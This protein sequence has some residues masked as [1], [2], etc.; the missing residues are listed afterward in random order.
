MTLFSGLP[1]L[2]STP[3]NVPSIGEIVYLASYVFKVGVTAA[4]TMPDTPPMYSA[5]IGILGDAGA[6]N[7]DPLVGPAGPAGV[8]NFTL[9]DQSDTLPIV[10]TVSDLPNDLTNTAE[11][12]GKYWL[13]DTLDDTGHVIMVTAYV[14]YGTNFR[15]YMSGSFGPPGPIP[16]V[17][18]TV[19]DI[20]DNEK[21]YVLTSG[22]STAP[23][24]D[25]FV[26]A[27]QGPTGIS[28]PFA[29]FPDFDEFEAAPQPFDILAFTGG[30]TSSGDPIWQ[31][32]RVDQSIVGPYSMPEAAFSPAAGVG[33]QIPIGVFAVPQQPFPWTPVVWGHIGGSGVS[34]STDPFMV[35]CEVLL[36]NQLSGQQ[37]S[38][39]IG[40]TTG[41]VNVMPHYS[42]PT[43]KSGSITPT[44]KTAVVPAFHTG[45]QGTIYINLYNDGAEQV[46]FFEP[47]NA[48]LF[49]MVVPIGESFASITGIPTSPYISGSGV[50]AAAVHTNGYR[51]PGGA[52]GHGQLSAGAVA[53]QFR[54]PLT[55]PGHGGLFGLAQPNAVAPNIPGTGTLSAVAHATKFTLTGHLAGHGTLKHT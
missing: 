47:G 45:T 24:W 22:P 37:V 42:T 13:L 40:N 41:V 3:S 17:E 4:Q 7:L 53:K 5:N 38:R 31:P 23:S 54:I 18:L 49:I 14:W 51:L 39:G 55:F 52:L 8:A 33:R 6:M 43:N 11:D 28:G 10:N 48:Q 16:A 27:P 34:L 35:G 9:R 29:Q 46:V 32:V 20:P 19:Q 30:Y 44:N 15:E 12:I 50:L 26:A 2:Q 25:F 1:A 36:G 21:S